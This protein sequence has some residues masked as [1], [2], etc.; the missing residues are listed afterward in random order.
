MAIEL[1]LAEIDLTELKGLTKSKKYL[2]I[3]LGKSNMIIPTDKNIKTVTDLRENTMELLKQTKV[4]GPT[5]IFHHSK[6]M[7]VMLSIDEYSNMTEMLEDYL[8]IQEAKESEENPQTGGINLKQLAKK[9]GLS[10]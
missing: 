1:A 2:R 8:D 7:A 5:M 3:A 10:I 4:S 9:Y 6:P